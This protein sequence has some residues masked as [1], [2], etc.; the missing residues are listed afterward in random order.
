[1]HSFN[2]DMENSD[3]ASSG[4]DGCSVHTL[5]ELLPVLYDVSSCAIIKATTKYNG[6]ALSALP[7]T[8]GLH[9]AAKFM[10]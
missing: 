6:G 5:S 1:M 10:Y 3:L 9:Q 8:Q 2:E 7:I 4:F